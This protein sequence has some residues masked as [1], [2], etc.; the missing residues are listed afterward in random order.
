MR[1]GHAVRAF[2]AVLLWAGLVS[3]PAA[4]HGQSTTATI[5]GTVRSE[6]GQPVPSA[7]VEAVNTETGMRRR[8]SAQRDGVYTLLGLQPGTYRISVSAMGQS[9]QSRTLQVL[10]GQ[11][12]TADFQLTSQ[13][14]ALEGITVV[15][16]RAVETQTSEVA[17]NIT[18]DQ[19][20]NLPNFER[21]FLDIARLAPG[22]TATNPNSTDKVIAAG[23][24]PAEAV[25]V[26]VD[27]A[28]Y[29]ND[30]LRGGVVGQDASKGNPFPQSALREFRVATQNF[31]AEYQRAGSAVITATTR[32]GTNRWEGEAFAFGV[33]DSWVARDAFTASR[34][35]ASPEYSRLQAGGSVGG[36]LVQDK[37]FFFGT[38]ELNSR[39]EPAYVRLGADSLKAPASVLSDLRQ[40]TG[41]FAQEFRQHLGFGKLTWNAS[42][43]STVDASLTVRSDRDFRGFGQQTAFEAS[44]NMKVRVYTGV[45]NWRW[46][47]GGD[48]LNEAQ[49]SAQAF[50]WNP[51][52]T[53]GGLVGREYVN[54]LRVGGKDSEQDFQ[55]KR[56]SLRDD[57][58]RSGVRFAGD[59]VFKGGFNV[60]FLRYE[61]G[62]LTN[63]NPLFRYRENESYARPFE[64]RFGFGDQ[65]IDTDNIQFGGYIQD[66]WSV[67]ERLVLNLGLRW[68]AETNMI[69]NGYATPRTLA[70]SL[71]GP[72]SGQLYVDQPLDGGGSQRVAVVD[73]LGG[74]ERFISNG[75][76]RPMYKKA[77]Q[78]R[79]G[80]SYDLTGDGRTVLFGGYGLYYDRTYWNT[81][82]DEQFRRQFSVLTVQFRGTEQECAA[83]DVPSACA[84]WNDRFYDP[85]QLRTLAGT[86]GRP[87]VFM[88]ANDLKPPHTH[89]FS[90]GLRQA[91]GPAVVTVSYNGVRGRDYTNFVRASPWGGL[92]PN[93]AQLFVTDDRVRTWYDAMQL[94]VERPL[95]DAA[96]WGG[97]IAYTL[98]RSE[99]QG[100]STDL[101][102][103]FDDRYPTVGDRPRRRA[104]G[105]QR[106][107]VVANAIVRLPW[108][109]RLSTI[110]TFGSGIAVNATDAS[111]GWDL[112]RQRT[113]VFEPPKRSF[114]GIGHVFATQ[115]VDLRLEKGV[116]VP[117]GQR[118]GLVVDLFNAFNNANYG[119]FESTI[120]PVADQNQDWRNRYG[121]PG[122]AGLGRRLQVGARYGFG[123]GAQ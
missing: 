22:I 83:S 84:V 30:V 107:S 18:R 104:P 102:W 101:F 112:I 54:I 61:A 41:Q 68:D 60:D 4:A 56:L 85:E 81:L 27:G 89:Q 63:A 119:C 59:H 5:R 53:N 8:A 52:W 98:S 46:S 117:R 55:Q 35:G 13:A 115:S 51:T 1:R 93:Y 49:V 15:G 9:P 88:V 3:S 123:G 29:K 97:S 34:G 90:A 114:L 28:T 19:I 2:A 91:V 20:Q 26:F 38:Y 77:F 40:R 75:D 37:L 74:L 111:Q 86:A 58:T 120:V 57:V 105:D 17:T 122:C 95:S 64:A 7:T 39:D 21:N 108:D 62:K 66:D 24:Q 118:V 32:S 100:Q 109:T 116:S 45:G 103:G 16:G 67:G 78:P 12:L 71:R 65:T 106:H 69:N 23:G 6:E 50:T 48:W 76:N 121:Q 82:L 87:E 70:D 44:E 25:N 10:I 80:A 42:E 11:S 92:G 36:P 43:S 96:R 113:Y 79:V 94:Q 47:G 110:A 72:L 33:N 31:K 73:E 14:V 99:E